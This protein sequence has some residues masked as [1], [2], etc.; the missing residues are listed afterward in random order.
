MLPQTFFG[1][2]PNPE[3]ECPPRIV[4]Y[5]TPATNGQILVYNSTT[6]TWEP[7]APNPGDITAVNTNL[8][9]TGGAASGSVT[10]DINNFTGDSGAGGLDGAVPA[11]AAGDAAAGKFLKADGTWAV[12]ASG[13]GFDELGQIGSNANTQL[14]GSG[15]IAPF[16]T[17]FVSTGKDVVIIFQTDVAIGAALSDYVQ[18]E[19]E[20]DGS[21]YNLGGN[22]YGAVRVEQA[23]YSIF[24]LCLLAIIPA[25]SAGSHN[26]K[27]K[28]STDGGS[29]YINNSG[30]TAWLTVLE[31]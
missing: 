21:S 14:T 17:S 22:A 18:L 6:D 15:Y 4:S 20:I 5:E 10:L 24:P 16:T 26:L 8:P 9:L 28:F 31:G 19:I 11:P 2:D 12:P 13:G 1:V 27:I 29:A 23:A 3:C 30:Y 7:A 25:L